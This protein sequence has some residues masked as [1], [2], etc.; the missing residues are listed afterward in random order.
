L[1]LILATIAIT[2]GTLT[3]MWMGEQ[4]A[5]RGIG[6]GISII[7]M[8]GIIARLPSAVFRMIS[9]IS[10]GSTD[11]MTF[12]LVLVIFVVVIGLVVFEE[13]GLRKIP[14]QYANRAMSGSMHG[15]QVH[16]LPFKVN[17]TGVI[18]IIFAS[19][20]LLVPSQV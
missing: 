16:F 5:E 3:L 7:I 19:S 1:F 14:I 17:P 8:S 13:K 15:G 20:L 9:S 2:T 4:I 11:P 12:L 18:P 6:N 10:K